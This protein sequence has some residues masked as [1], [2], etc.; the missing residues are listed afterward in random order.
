MIE[1]RK[2][3][4]AMAKAPWNLHSANAYLKSWTQANID[5]A[6][7]NPPDLEYIFSDV[8]AFTRSD[9]HALATPKDDG[10]G[11]LVKAKKKIRGGGVLEL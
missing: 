8:R 10:A 5:Q 11:K 3:G 7:P 1:F 9:P 4:M 6:W 2:T